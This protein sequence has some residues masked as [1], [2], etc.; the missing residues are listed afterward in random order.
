MNEP[1]LVLDEEDF[2]VLL[3]EL[4]EI[5]AKYSMRLIVSLRQKSVEQ[6]A[7]RAK[8]EQESVKDVD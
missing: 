2:N 7:E 6:A 4:G 1:A 8:Q 5:P 3:N